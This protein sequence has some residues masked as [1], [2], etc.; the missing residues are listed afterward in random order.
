[1]Y[2][3][4][5]T[6]YRLRS[7]VPRCARPRPVARRPESLAS[8]PLALVQPDA[9]SVERLRRPRVPRESPDVGSKR[10]DG[11]GALA[12]GIAGTPTQPRPCTGA[13]SGSPPTGSTRSRGPRGS[14][15]PRE[16]RRGAERPRRRRPTR[17]SASLP[18][19]S[20]PRVCSRPSRRTPPDFPSRAKR[21]RRRE[22]SFRP[23][24]RG[25]PRRRA[26]RRR[27]P[28]RP[29][30][31][32]GASPRPRDAV[33]VFSAGVWKCSESN[34]YARPSRTSAPKEAFSSPSVAP[35]C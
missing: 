33:V 17:L 34:A 23:P 6:Y 14:R 13:S 21:R 31:V 35:L 16:R 7:V 28:S 15:G 8:S 19:T 11:R 9:P 5:H 27:R 2:Y 20:L 10:G 26:G 30:R 29:P 4:E 12:S 32:H 3:L 22:T 25:P 1:M 24:P 18:S